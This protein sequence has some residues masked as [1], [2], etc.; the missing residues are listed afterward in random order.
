MGSIRVETVENP[1]HSRLFVASL[2]ET[3]GAALPEKLHSDQSRQWQPLPGFRGGRQPS[4][5]QD[6]VLGDGLQIGIGEGGVIDVAGGVHEGVLVVGGLE[7]EQYQG[8]LPAV[9]PAGIAALEVAPVVFQPGPH[10]PGCGGPPLLFHEA[11]AVALGQVQDEG[12]VGADYVAGIVMPVSHGGAGGGQQVQQIA[13]SGTGVLAVGM[14]A[15]VV[16]ESR[17][18]AGWDAAVHRTVPAVTA[19]CQ[20]CDAAC[21]RSSVPTHPNAALSLWAK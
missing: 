13:V 17:W 4:V 16:M 21:A 2:Q 6:S 3:P 5:S 18:A 15:K 14:A 10:P 9:V 8:Q 19:P 11:V 7:Y 12:D 1:C 20:G